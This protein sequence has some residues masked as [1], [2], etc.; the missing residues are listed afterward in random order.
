MSDHLEDLVTEA[1][2]EASERLDALSTLEVVRLMGE[3]DR[4]VAE[5]VAGQAAAIAEAVDEVVARWPRGGRLV[6]VGA[7]TSGRLGVLDAAE[8]PPTFRTPPERV[9]GLI[10]GG[11]VALRC[12][13]EGAEDDADRGA[14]AVADLAVGRA[15]VVVGVAARGRTPYV[16]GALAG[17]RAAGA[18]TVGL[19]CNPGSR[20]E[21]EVD[22]AITPVVGPEVVSGSTR[23][24]AGTAT[25]MVLN[26]ISTATMVRLGKTYGNSMVD[27]QASND[28]LRAR[29]RRMVR[30]LT[31][32]PVGEVDGLLQR[33][34]G[35]V[36][37]ALVAHWRGVSADRARQLLAGAD[38]RVR[39]AVDDGAPT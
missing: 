33:C 39:A 7:G 25:K 32:L 27:V 1:S 5:A 13:V 3:E 36:K 6:Y 17:A 23:L 24:K 2:N 16:L 9:V 4:G 37:T 38:G 26:M 14:A 10:A 19:S 11:D 29:A 22:L 21:R 15:A 18:V 30:R 28:K 34:D 8:C 12:S 35:E 20:M 31:G